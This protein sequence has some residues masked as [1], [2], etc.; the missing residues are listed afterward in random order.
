MFYSLYAHKM[1]KVRWGDKST[2]FRCDLLWIQQ[3]LPEARFIHVVRDGRDVWLSQR[4]TWFNQGHSAETHAGYWKRS[5]MNTQLR[6]RRFRHFLQIRY[7]DMVLDTRN[8][9]MRIADFLELSYHPA[10]ETYFETAD[11]RQHEIA[12]LKTV[13]GRVIR[14]EERIAINHRLTNPPDCTRVS[15][16]RK[17]MKPQD[18]VD[19]WRIAGDVLRQIG[20]RA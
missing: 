7:E 20:Y 18:C 16:W 5:I 14:Q 11:V 13:D 1:G 15:R 9:L 19:Y 6:S 12:D 17:E 4:D 8:Q 3:L 10:M 2:S